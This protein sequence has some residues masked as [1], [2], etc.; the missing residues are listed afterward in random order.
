MQFKSKPVYNYV[1][2]E[3][4]HNDEKSND[5]ILELLG[6]NAEEVMIEDEL[7]TITLKSEE[8]EQSQV[9]LLNFGDFLVKDS[10]GVYS[11]QEAIEFTKEYEL[12]IE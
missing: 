7:C 10:N 12:V 9:L 2:A 11:A 8:D 5:A 3:I 1:Q 6:D 4:F